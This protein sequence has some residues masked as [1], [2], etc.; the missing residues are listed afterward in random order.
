MAAIEQVR[1]RQDEIV[2]LLQA[3]LPPNRQLT[4]TTKRAVSNAFRQPQNTRAVRRS[5][6][7]LPPPSKAA[8]DF[9]FRALGNSNYRSL[10]ERL[11]NE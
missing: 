4:D 5:K 8:Q 7:A 10:M 2:H 9:I 3:Q 11:A 1:E 6:K